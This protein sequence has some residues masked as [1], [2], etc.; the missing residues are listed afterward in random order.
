M[1]TAR[2]LACVY[3]TTQNEVCDGAES[4]RREQATQQSKSGN[5]RNFDY[6]IL[7]PPY[8]TLP[9]P[10]NLQWITVPSFDV[11]MGADEL[12][13]TLQ[14]EMT[15][16]PLPVGIALGKPVLTAPCSVTHH[17]DMHQRYVELKSEIASPNEIHFTLVDNDKQAPRGLY[18]LWLLTDGGAPSHAKWVV[19]R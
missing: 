11:N 17:S 4:A 6:E 13:Y 1:D 2:R 18:M 15:C 7:S 5:G 12:N 9:R 14:Y 3:F 16:D 8:M 19:L 10:T